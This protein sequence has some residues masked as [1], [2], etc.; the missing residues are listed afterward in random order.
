MQVLAGIVGIHTALVFGFMC[1]SFLLAN[2]DLAGTGWAYDGSAS[3]GTGR[4]SPACLS[5]CAG[6]NVVMTGIVLF[7][8]NFGLIMLLHKPPPP[9]QVW[10]TRASSLCRPPVV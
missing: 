10:P 8:Y 9:F 2:V 7:L 1:T 5:S 6:V 4:A 3:E